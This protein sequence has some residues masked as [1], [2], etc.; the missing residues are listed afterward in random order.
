MSSWMCALRWCAALVR[1]VR[2]LRSCHQTDAA[3]VREYALLPLENLEEHLNPDNHDCEMQSREGESEE[4]QLLDPRVYLSDDEGPER[5]PPHQWDYVVQAAPASSSS[6]P[7]PSAAPVSA[8]Q[9]THERTHATG[10]GRASFSH[11]SA[12]TLRERVL[13]ELPTLSFAVTKINQRGRRQAR[14]LRLTAHGIENMRVKTTEVS[15]FFEYV[16]VQLLVANRCG[17][18]ARTARSVPHAFSQ[19]QHHAV[20]AALQTRSPSVR[21]RVARGHPDCAR[22]RTARYSG[23]SAG[24]GDA[25]RRHRLPA[26]AQPACGTCECVQVAR[27]CS[28]V[29][30]VDPF[31]HPPS[32]KKK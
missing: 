29:T 12:G 21:V 6:F 23:A 28:I 17:T 16:S 24:K 4:A 10:A 5:P 14:M 30:Y 3:Y 20:L 1:C 8:F 13:G 32:K 26:R 19:P 2:A 22:D 27:L 15:S 9:E 11:A 25:I 7:P 18:W 31:P